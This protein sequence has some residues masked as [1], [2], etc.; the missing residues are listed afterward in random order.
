MKTIPA[1][2]EMKPLAYGMAAT[3]ARL[4][5]QA[6]TSLVEQPANTAVKSLLTLFGDVRP[7]EMPRWMKNWTPSDSFQ[8]LPPLE[9]ILNEINKMELLG[10]PCGDKAAA[11]T[12]QK[13]LDHFGKPDNWDSLVDDYLDELSQI[14]SDLLNEIVTHIRRNCKFFPKIADLLECVQDRI[15]SRN[16][17][18][19]KL[20]IMADYARKA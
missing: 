15:T 19:T 6:S 13:A 8:Q 14:P 4:E 5:A 2:L 7:D 16:I 12:I 9:Q 17:K 18:L 11:V 3:L 20:R 10:R 1:E